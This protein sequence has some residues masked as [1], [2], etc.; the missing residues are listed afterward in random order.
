[1][2]H[3]SPACSISMQTS[4]T[5]VRFASPVRTLATSFLRALGGEREAGL[6]VF[7]SMNDGL[8][9]I[10]RVNEPLWVPPSDSS[11]ISPMSLPT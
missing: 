11:S 8:V 6:L 2:P 9:E 7:G 3:D 1:M 10:L 4:A 5:R